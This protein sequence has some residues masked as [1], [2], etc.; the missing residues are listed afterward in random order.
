M[1]DWTVEW[2]VSMMV[3]TKATWTAGMSVELKAVMKVAMTVFHLVETRAQKWVVHWDVM[4]AD[5]RAE[6]TVY[7]WVGKLDGMMVAPMVDK[8]ER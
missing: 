3:G 8:M 7:R 2:M 1:V 6:W 4:M 5:L